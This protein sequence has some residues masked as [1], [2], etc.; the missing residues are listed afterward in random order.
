MAQTLQ[1]NEDMRRQWLADIS[2]ELRT[3]LAILRGETE[4]VLDGVRPITPTTISSLHAEI[5]QLTRLVDDL[6]QLS[7]A[8]LGGL[9]YQWQDVELAAALS[10]TGELFQ[11]KFAQKGISLKLHTAKAQGLMLQGDPERLQQLFAIILDNS[12]KYTDAPGSLSLSLD[13]EGDKLV[14]DFLDT[15]PGVPENSLPPPF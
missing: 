15:P 4:A 7:L 12:L 8:D 13:R 5:L 10:Q 3:P 11:G 14:V 2:H 6:Y 1:R 9:N